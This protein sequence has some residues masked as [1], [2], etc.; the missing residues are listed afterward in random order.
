MKGAGA[1]LIRQ[2]ADLIRKDFNLAQLSI[3]NHESLLAEV[4]KIVSHYLDMDL[5]GLLNILY[6][7]DIS[8]S[9]VKNILSSAPPEE[10]AS[11]LANKIL[12]RELLKVQTRLRYRANQSD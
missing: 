9:E 10:M 3:T 8:E 11:L 12:Q 6:R 2:S 1:N 7:I 5:N 4:S